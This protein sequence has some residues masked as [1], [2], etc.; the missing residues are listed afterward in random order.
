MLAKS[1]FVLIRT[2]ENTGETISIHDLNPICAGASRDQIIAFDEQQNIR[3]CLFI[4][5]AYN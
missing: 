1:L 2:V 3:V 4:E 5:Y